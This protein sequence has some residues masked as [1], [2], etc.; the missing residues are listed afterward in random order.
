[1]FHI[2]TMSQYFNL[3]SV[4]LRN[5]SK[6]SPILND[7]KS[8]SKS[9]TSLKSKS[10]SKSVTSL[11]SKSKSATP[12]KSIYDGFVSKTNKFIFDGNSYFIFTGSFYRRHSVNDLKKVIKSFVDLNYPNSLHPKLIENIVSLLEIDFF[13][14]PSLLNSA[15]FLNFLDGVLNL[16]NGELVNHSP[17][18][19]FTYVQPFKYK[20]QTYPN[21]ILEFITGCVSGVE[22]K[23][24]LLLSLAYCMIMNLT[25]YEVF[26]E[27]VG[28]G[29]T[30]KSTFINLMRALIHPAQATASS[31]RELEGNRFESMNLEGKKLIYIADSEAYSGHLGKLKSHVSGDTVRAE[32]KFKGVTYFSIKAIFIFAG[33]YS[34]SSKDFTSGIIRRRILIE[35]NNVIKAREKLIE[36][37]EFQYSGKLSKELSGF[38]KYLLENRDKYLNIMEENVGK[39]KDQSE[40]FIFSFLGECL[41]EG[42]RFYVGN[43]LLPATYEGRHVYPIFLSY[44]KAHRLNPVSLLKFVEVLMDWA[45]VNGLTLDKGKD[46]IGVYYSGATINKEA[47]RNY[48]LADS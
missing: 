43:A 9:V 39:C 14:D 16:E 34:I 35:F 45:K 32:L 47:I 48:V 26:L 2:I 29:S 18:L 15:K 1:M 3:L 36:V 5:F 10:K 22:H 40:N 41:M 42:D 24:D 13:V 17:T 27:L 44:C 19:L 33:N 37:S 38:I 7:K 23:R 20:D 31:L 11:K 21:D 12:L 4:Y 30:G 8:K 28:S 46:R 6:K 25:K